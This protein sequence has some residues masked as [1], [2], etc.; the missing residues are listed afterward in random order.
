[1]MPNNSSPARMDSILACEIKDTIKIE[2]ADFNHFCIIVKWYSI[3]LNEVPHI[4]CATI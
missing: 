4:Y 2:L 1:M 3:I